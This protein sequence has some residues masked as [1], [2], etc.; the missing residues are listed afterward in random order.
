M[1]SQ[2][3]KI[4]HILPSMRFRDKVYILNKYL[5]LRSI[6]NIKLIQSTYSATIYWMTIM[7]QT[8]FWALML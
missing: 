4:S 2:I 5:Q 7:C 1:L 3:K 6:E 8:L